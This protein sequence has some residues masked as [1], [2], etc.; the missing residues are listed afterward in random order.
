MV[1]RAHL[2]VTLYVQCLSGE[3]L[4]T[5]KM[6]SEL[7]CMLPVEMHDS[8]RSYK[9]RQM[10]L[11]NAVVKQPSLSLLL[12]LCYPL[13]TA[14]SS[15]QKFTVHYEVTPLFFL[16]EF[17]TYVSRQPY[18]WT[19]TVKLTSLVQYILKHVPIYP[20][21]FLKFW[22]KITYELQQSLSLCK[23]KSIFFIV[24]PC[25]LFQSLLYCSNSCTSL[26]FKILKFHIKTLK[27]NPYM[28]RSNLKPSSGGPWPYFVR[29]LHW[30]VNLHVNQFSNSV[31]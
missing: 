4:L 25:M 30:N 19:F 31:T 28:F 21:K 23:R 16:G 14:A 27:I 18:T 15:D 24:V 9:A 17:L 1:A 12:S 5:I 8:W 29:L 22:L 2:S 7:R 20:N 10:I 6:N 26:H 13:F 11:G 3:I